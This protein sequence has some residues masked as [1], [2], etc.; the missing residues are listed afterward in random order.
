[1]GERRVPKQRR[2]ED[3]DIGLR[4]KASEDNPIKKPSVGGHHPPW[5]RPT[6]YRLR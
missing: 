6:D 2:E 5:R 3:F 4:T 1:M